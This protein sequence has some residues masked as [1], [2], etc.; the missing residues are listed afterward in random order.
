[1]T[2]WSSFSTLSGAR[3]TT[4]NYDQYRGWLNSKAY[5]DG[6][7]PSYQYTPSGRLS[8]RTWARGLST[9]YSYDPSGSILT[10]AYDSDPANNYTTPWVA[11]SYDRRGRQNANILTY[12]PAYTTMT[13]TLAYNDGGQLVSESYSGG[14]LDGLRV[15]NSYDNLLRRTN[16]VSWGSSALGRSIYGY[17]GASRLSTVSDGTNKATY[18]YLT[19][20]TLVGQVAFQSG[21]TNVM[22]AVKAYDFLNRLLTVTNTPVDSHVYTYNSANQRTGVSAADGSYWVY[23]YDSLGQVTSGVKHWRDGSV[24]A[25]EQFGYSFDTIG[26]RTSTTTGGDTNGGSL[27]SANYTNNTLNQIIGRSVPGYLDV[28]GVSIA[29]NVVTVSG[30]TAYRKWEYFR[31]ELPAVNTNTAIWS[32]ITVSATG[33]SSLSGNLFLAKS[34]ETF[35]YDLDGNLLTDGRWNYYW[36]CEN[37]L[38]QMTANTNVGPQYQLNFSY[39]ARSRRIQKQVSTNSTSVYTNV[40]L[41]DGWNLIAELAPNGSVLRNYTWG[42][43]LSGTMQ[44]AGGVGGLLWENAMIGNTNYLAFVGFDGNGNVSELVGTGGTNL[45]QYEYG[46]FGEVIRATGPMA[47]LNPFRFSTKYQDDESD[48]LY[49]GMRWYSASTGQWLSRDPIGEKGGVNL[50]ICS[51]NDQID[52]FDILGLTWKIERQHHKRAHAT[53]ENGDT[54]ADLAQMIHFDTKDYKQWLRPVGPT[55]MPASA[56]TPIT[57]CS[58]FTIPNTI[59]IDLGQASTIDLGT[60]TDIVYI[61]RALAMSDVRTWSGQGFLAVP[62]EAPTDENIMA[63]LASK[64]IYGYEYVGHGWTPGIIN[65]YDYFGR[66]GGVGPDRYSSYG[67]AF[68]TLRACYSA[69]KQPIA[70]RHYRFNAWEANVS[71]KGWFAGYE[72]SVDALNELGAW[73]ITHGKNDGG[74][75]GR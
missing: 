56:N 18:I 50:Y 70:G 16:L 71:T 20:S 64:D 39:D 33:Q 69:D 5:D 52:F 23:S 21:S 34:P 41:Y 73:R 10:V 47:K 66:E 2:N 45:A 30:N 49:Y 54:I 37:R 28:K 48:L 75:S 27:R 72:G 9:H 4:W 1:M 42:S 22:T 53:P 19:N 55:S 12:I 65:T 58:Q 35:T 31:T 61:W 57:S 51:G 63:H 25:G 32:N 15:S 59:Y 24:V 68:M 11:Y 38:V 8:V 62:I 40:F 29:T 13:T 43:D 36:D 7:G 14:A 67:I 17:D 3:V 46:P 44:G 74:I 60:P 6:N 26:N